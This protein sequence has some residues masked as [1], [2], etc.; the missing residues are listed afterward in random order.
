MTTLPGNYKLYVE[1]GI[2]AEKARVAL[3]NTS[4]WAD[5]AFG[6]KPDLKK[7]EQFIQ[8]KS[9]LIGMP[10]AAE[11][12]KTG[13][14]VVEMDAN[15]LRQIEWL[16][17]YTIQTNKEKEAL[18]AKNEELEKRVARIERLLNK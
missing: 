10:S 14:D 12:V 11:L 5:D 3:E 17:E 4:K 9:H 13:V 7:L 2:L 1:D 6:K 8:E 18:Q 15:L 16:W